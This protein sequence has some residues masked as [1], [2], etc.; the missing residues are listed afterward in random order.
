M[1]VEYALAPGL[2]EGAIL[3]GSFHLAIR[4]PRVRSLFRFLL[5]CQTITQR[6]LQRIRLVSFLLLLARL[7]L[8][9]S[10]ASTPPSMLIYSC[11]CV[12]FHSHAP[13]VLYLLPPDL[14]SRVYLLNDNTLVRM[15]ILPIPPDL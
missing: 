14:P 9:S 10:I 15:Y 6:S 12:R 7:S 4:A 2:Q 5:A 3:D 1:Q 13:H 8:S 11:A